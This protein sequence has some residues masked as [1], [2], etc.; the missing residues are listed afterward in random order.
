MDPAAA[1]RWIRSSPP[2][3]GMS[4]RSL[5]KHLHARGT[6]YSARLDAVRVALATTL[7]RDTSMSIAEICHRVGF[8]SLP[9]FSRFFT[10]QTGTPPSQHRRR[11]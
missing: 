11:G 2:L 3:K 8:D 9:G 4:V 7:L 6:S 10:M 5:Q 1:I